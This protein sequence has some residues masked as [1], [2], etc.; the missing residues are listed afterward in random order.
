MWSVAWKHLGA[1]H[2]SFAGACAAVLSVSKTSRRSECKKCSNLS[3][4][5]I[6][7]DD[8]CGAVPKEAIWLS[9][10][11]NSWGWVGLLAQALVG[12]ELGL[13]WFGAGHLSLAWADREP[14]SSPADKCESNSVLAFDQHLHCASAWLCWWCGGTAWPLLVLTKGCKWEWGSSCCALLTV[15]LALVGPGRAFQY[16]GILVFWHFGISIF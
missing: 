5:C 12:D 13:A 14:M 3:H 7:C 8:W 4:C 10:H 9:L 16:F 15:L 2:S 11:S 1:M 6:L